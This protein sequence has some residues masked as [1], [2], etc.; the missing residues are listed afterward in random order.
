[1]A[2]HFRKGQPHRNEIKAIDFLVEQLPDHYGVYT[3]IEMPVPGGR[4]GQA[5]EH[6]V[7]VFTPYM[8]FAV[9][10]K[11]W[12][13][14]IIAG[15]ERWTLDDGTLK[16][17][18]VALQNQKARVLKTVL[19]SGFPRR[20]G[21]PLWV[22]GVVFLTK[23]G[24]QPEVDP[25]I[26]GLVYTHDDI[27]GAIT[28]HTRWG[29]RGEMFT[30]GQARKL[31]ENIN[32]GRPTKER[33]RF[34]DFTLKERLP[35]HHK[36]PYEAWRGERLGQPRTLHIYP[37][38]ADN[39]KREQKLRALAMREVNLQDRLRSGPDLLQYF[40]HDRIV[41]DREPAYILYFEDTSRLLPLMEWV[42]RHNPTADARFEVALRVAR[43][44]R[45]IH[46][47]NVVHR[48]LSPDAIL[49]SDESLPQ[50]VRL[51]AIELG[52]DL[53][54]EVRT[55]S[56]ADLDDPTYRYMSPE[57]LVSGEATKRSDAFALGA[58]LYELINARP[59]FDKADDVL[60]HYTIPPMHVGEI[61]IPDGPA[62]AIMTLLSRDPM[63]RPELDEL[64]D[65]LSLTAVPEI[66]ATSP[67]STDLAPGVTIAGRY[68]LV[69][70]IREG[71]SGPIWIAIQP[72]DETQVVL[73]FGPIGDAHLLG[74]VDALRDLVHPNVVRYR[75]FCPVDEQRVL[76]VTNLVEGVDGALHVGAGDQI[77]AA[78]INKI[79]KGLFAALSALH[80]QGRLHRDVKPENVLLSDGSLEPV[81][82]DFGLSSPIGAPGELAS[83]T[84]AYKDPQL[85]EVGEW[86][87][88]DDLYAAWI[89]LYE[90]ATGRYP[91]TGDAVNRHLALN[92]DDF[93]DN[94]SPEIKARLI[95]VFRKALGPR[96]DRWPEAAAASDALH[97]AAEAPVAP[98][99]TKKQQQP[100]LVLKS[101]VVL[102]AGVQPQ[103]PIHT[104]PL[105]LR[106]RRCL[107]RLGVGV[108]VQLQRVTPA[109]L[110]DM[111]NV[112]RKTVSEIMAVRA[113]LNATLGGFTDET[114]EV[115][116]K[117]LARPI[118]PALTESAEPLS[119]LG[120]TL[121]A[122]LRT[123]MIELGV[124]TVGELA[125]L[126]E[127]DLTGIEGLGDK[128]I[129]A[130]R[131][132]L[133]RLAKD[134]APPESLD[135]LRG[136]LHKELKKK[137]EYFDTVYGLTSGTPMA[138]A[139][140]AEHHGVSRQQVDQAVDLAPLRAAVSAGQFLADAVQAALP[141]CGFAHLEAVAD[142]LEQRMPAPGVSALGFARLGAMLLTAPAELTHRQHPHMHIDLVCRPPWRP[143]L[144]G[145]LKSALVDAVDDEPL[146]RADAQA[147]VWQHAKEAG[148][149][150]VLQRTEADDA[151]L[152]DALLPLVADRVHQ[153][154]RDEALYGAGLAFE[155]ALIFLAD[156]IVL[157]TTVPDLVERV[158]QTFAALTPP[159]EEAVAEA[160]Q[161]LDWQVF[162]DGV[163]HNDPDYR[164]VQPAA[165]VQTD[166]AL[167]EAHISEDGSLDLSI[168]VQARATGGFKVV[169][170]PA[171][172]HHRQCAAV[173]RALDATLVDLDRVIIEALQNSG[174]WDEAL[175]FEDQEEPDFSWFEEDL[176]AALDGALSE[177]QPGRVTVLGR[178]CLLG[179]MGLTRWVSGLY[180]RSRGGRLGLIV[181]APPADIIDGR[182][183]LNA[184]YPLPYTPD[185]AAPVIRD[186]QE[187]T[188]P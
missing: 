121:S 98:A 91:F 63:S 172:S 24:A 93:S 28:D 65:E 106:A 3:N 116:V 58:T 164:P 25:G 69:E 181:F 92:A 17:S 105:G 99:Q 97:K 151:A 136:L 59:L 133:K 100:G 131:T 178:P 153:T 120:R 82:I 72:F 15:R 35:V 38:Q 61:P 16:N 132:A 177:A 145:P 79:G 102:P 124:T 182:V 14:K 148:L 81:L 78:T 23:K 57:L 184:V 4:P 13:G 134:D 87:V 74:E 50:T 188:A 137:F 48:R 75:D 66:E 109:M 143:A 161:M 167:P 114:A 86:Q 40:E 187:Q 89:T 64:I 171:G 175:F 34:A 85:Y 179:P 110:K 139:E 119:A 159:T 49:V 60:R 185:M 29:S 149:T 2:R 154:P 107:G 157:P 156:Q 103:T 51:G 5:Y 46:Q 155:D 186:L 67:G 68:E 144:V 90:I 115:E 70:P 37:T 129:E 126:S 84:P 6:D 173:A 135:E 170:L 54:Q 31:L 101:T 30:P 125:S 42:R 150:P 174:M 1:M 41:D 180:E 183:K 140:A 176:I 73:K 77:T 45:Y 7:I 138:I 47:R 123:R 22:Q 19:A 56:R 104:L 11:H 158:Q 163:V 80:N 18:P 147:I 52:R 39:E 168:L 141:R 169:A 12:G 118:A 9:E 152:L 8:V 71:V 166:I 94:I 108:A 26:D 165:E 112:G 128:K 162:D 83:G 142:M 111:R 21:P 10:L 76:L 32:G 44:L 33:R 27:I 113:A 117:P 95:E 43:A 36:V 20:A 88:A 130:I 146:A 62:L 122:K 160:A 96:E 53:T 127:V 55:I